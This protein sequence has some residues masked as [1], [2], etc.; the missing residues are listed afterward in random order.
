MMKW[1]LAAGAAALAISVPAAAERGG[2]KGGGQQGHDAH[3]QKADRGGGG[4]KA[5]GQH[6]GGNRQ[7]STER[8]GGDRGKQ[9]RFV[10]DNNRGHGHDNVRASARNDDRGRSNFRIEN[11]QGDQG[12]RH[13]KLENRQGDNHQGNQGNRRFEDGDGVRVARLDKDRGHGRFADFSGDKVFRVRDFDRRGGVRFR[14]VDRDDLFIRQ[15]GYGVG[16]CP[17]GLAKKAVACMPP[18][19]AARFVGQPLLAAS[20]FGALDPLPLSLRSL[21]WDNDD[22]Y[23]RYGGGYLYRVDRDDEL[24]ASMIP[25]FGAALLGQPLQPYYTNNN[26]RPSY[27]NAFYPNSPY[28][29]YQYGYGYVYETD[30]MSGLVENVIPTYD[31]GYGVGQLLPSSYGYYNVPFAYRSSFADNDDY[32]Y[33]YAPGAIYRVDR[34]TALISAVAALLTNGLSVGQPLPAGYS[35]YNVPLAYRSTYYDTP[36]SWYRYDNGYI[37]DVDPGSHMVRSVVYVV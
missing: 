20:R 13:A 4:Q 2:G 16:G 8:G 32:Y 24:I 34:E 25:L 15:I 26:Y 7:M 37:Y 11:H 33:R 5:R 30:C 21:Y 35:A 18:G 27:F 19:Q 29:C 3:A 36:D 9:M 31:Y 6:G 23:Y 12:R 17:P 1:M 14:D 10:Q 28:D 22:Y